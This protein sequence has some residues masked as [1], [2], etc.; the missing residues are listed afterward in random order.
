MT[1]GLWKRS[2]WKT[3]LQMALKAVEAAYLIAAPPWIWNLQSKPKP[4]LGR[5][6]GPPARPQLP[7]QTRT[8]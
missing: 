4:I 5:G 2:H 3:K 8:K 1:S 7:A 6:R